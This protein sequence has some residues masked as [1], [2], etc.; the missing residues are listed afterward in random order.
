ML[1]VYFFLVEYTVAS[2]A[3]NFMGSSFDYRRAT[4]K[5]WIDNLAAK[6]PKE[7]KPYMEWPI[8][9]ARSLL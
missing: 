2:H 9:L 1:L 8:K 5:L 7:Y 4:T 6:V 3:M